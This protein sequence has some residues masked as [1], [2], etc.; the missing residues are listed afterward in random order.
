MKKQKKLSKLQKAI[1][2]YILVNQHGYK[3]NHGKIKN[4]VKYKDMGKK[5]AEDFNKLIGGNRESYIVK[6]SFSVSLSNSINAL[7]RR[8]LI[9][10]YPYHQPFW[11]RDKLLSLTEDGIRIATIKTTKV[12]NG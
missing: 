12:L 4:V 11:H 1:L 2:S 6:P 8:G 5:I 3:N 7:K 10:Q 9:I